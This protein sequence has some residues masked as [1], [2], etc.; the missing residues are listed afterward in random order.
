MFGVV[1]SRPRPLEYSATLLVCA[2]ALLASAQVRA[3][4][5]AKAADKVKMVM[6]RTASSTTFVPGGTLDITLR[7]ELRGGATVRALGIVETIPEGFTFVDLLGGEKPEVFGGPGSGGKLELAWVTV[8][9]FPITFSYRVK[10]SD[11]AIATRGFSG[12]AVFR[13]GGPEMRSDAV[14]TW[15]TQVPSEHDAPPTPATAPL[16]LIGEPVPAPGGP[17]DAPTT[18]GAAESAPSQSPRYFKITKS[19]SADQLV[20]IKK[21]PNKFGD[22]IGVVRVGEVLP[23]VAVQGKWVQVE[24]LGVKGYLQT[25]VG[26]VETR[27]ELQ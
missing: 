8:P 17:K 11:S 7:L 13:C 14:T 24:V 18:A 3:A 4:E 19:A 15:V 2:L 16:A 26:K 23:V 1:V 21:V 12:F 6:T 22:A 9:E 25:E 5:S 20:D 10:T 27:L